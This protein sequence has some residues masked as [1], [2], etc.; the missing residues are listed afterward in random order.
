MPLPAAVPPDERRLHGG[1]DRSDT[2]MTQ[3][4]ADQLS[5]QYPEIE[6]GGAGTYD[7]VWKTSPGR[8]LKPTGSWKEK[9]NAQFVFEHPADWIVPILSEP[10]IIQENPPMWGIHTKELQKITNIYLEIFITNLGF[11]SLIPDFESE[12]A[13]DAIQ[14]DPDLVWNVDIK[15]IENTYNQVQY[16]LEQN[17]N[18]DMLDL[19]IHGGNVGWDDD[20]RL[21]LFDLG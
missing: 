13:Q 17:N 7:T 11:K 4:T 18:H 5:Q 8:I 1:V 16:I 10:Q 12:W 2:R 20:G 6:Y 9:N 14:S 15:E 3:E 19:E 21:K